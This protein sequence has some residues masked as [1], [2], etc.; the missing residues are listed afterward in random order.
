MQMIKR[1]KFLKLT[2]L[3][4]SSL[5]ITTASAAVY[6][7]MYIDANVTSYTAKVYFTTTGAD[8]AEVAGTEIGTGGTSVSFSSLSGWPNATRVYEK[9]VSINNTDSP[10]NCILAV[11]S[12]SDGTKLDQLLFNVT[13]GSTVS[14]LDALSSSPSITFSLGTGSSSNPSATVAVQLKWKA[15]AQNNDV[16]TVV[17]ELKVPDEGTNE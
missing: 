12:I 11:K 14:S 6:N 4:L 15:A 17:L 8:D 1:G 7:L 2:M 10:K 3:L 9:V 16:V 13:I 5:L